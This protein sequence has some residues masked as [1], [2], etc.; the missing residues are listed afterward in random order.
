MVEGTIE[1]VGGKVE[2]AAGYLTGDPGIRV[3]GR[4]RQVAGKAQ[5]AYGKA[6][7]T[8]SNTSDRLQEAAKHHLSRRCY[9]PVWSDSYMGPADCC[10]MN[11]MA[12]LTVRHV[13]S[14]RYTKPVLLGE[15]RMMLRPRDSHDLRILSTRLAIAPQPAA[16]RWLHDVFENSVAIVAFG[17]PAAELKIESEIEIEHFESG[18]PNCPIEEYA[19]TYPFSYSAAEAP[20]LTR[21]TERHYPDPDHEVDAWAKSFLNPKGPTKTL[22]MLEAMTGF[23]QRDGLTYAAREAEGVQNPLDTLHMRSGSCRDFALLMIEGAR[24]LGLAARFVSGYLYVPSADGATNV[25]GSATH[26]WVQ[27]YLP[28]SGW[29]EFDPTNGILGNRDLIRVAVVRDPAQAVPVAGTWTGVPADFLGMTV[30]VSV[31]ADPAKVTQAQD[32]PPTLA[33]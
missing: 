3:E 10:S 26:A 7:D 22:G 1:N 5:T 19:A 6:A 24:S 13:T 8:V 29:I 2:E 11:G 21:S 30:E 15:H 20:D 4:V 14:Y 33:R 25:G 18:E 12:F 27:I 31:T 16:L 9:W 23:V 28:G 17:E 32:S